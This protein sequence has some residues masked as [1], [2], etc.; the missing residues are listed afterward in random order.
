MYRIF[1]RVIPCNFCNDILFCL[2]PLYHAF[3]LTAY[4]IFFTSLPILVY[5]IFEQHVNSDALQSQPRLYRYVMCSLLL[6]WGS[7]VQFW[8]NKY[9]SVSPAC[10]FVLSVFICDLNVGVRLVATITREF[11]PP[12]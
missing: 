8:I 4:N 6:I 2:Q 12:I 10:L 7:I 1:L 9:S 5:G 3:F 11:F